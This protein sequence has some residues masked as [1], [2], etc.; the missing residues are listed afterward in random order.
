MS[1]SAASIEMSQHIGDLP[2]NVMHG[3][4]LRQATCG[5]KRERTEK[6]WSTA[7]NIKL[8]LLKYVEINYVKLF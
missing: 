7:A 6:G 2:H 8:G 1:T 4:M 5:H 3:K